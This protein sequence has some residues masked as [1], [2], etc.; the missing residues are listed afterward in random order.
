MLR[1]R[2]HLLVVGV[3]V[4]GVGGVGLGL[5]SPAAAAATGTVV[6]NEVQTS[7]DTPDYIELTNTGATAVDISGYQLLD[8]DD[9]D[10][11][12]VPADTTLAPGAFVAF[13][14][15]PPFGL[16]GG[17]DSARLFA[18]DG[19]TLLDSFT[20]TT[21]AA[22]SWGRCPDG[23]GEFAVT[24]S[25]TR[26]AAND[27]GP[28]PLPPVRSDAVAWPGP[29]TVAVADG[30]GTLG[31]DQ[32]G[33]FLEAGA[34]LADSVLWSVQNDPGV[35]WRLLWNGTT[36]TPDTANGWAHGK[37]LRYPD[38]T[39]EPDSE[40]VT[41]V[42]GDSSRG[43]F[44]S[45]ERD[46]ADDEVSK[47]AILRF[48]V[49]GSD[50][51]L[52]ATDQWDMTT[53]LPSVE[54]NSGFEAL[55][56]VPDAALVA[57]GLLTGT[58]PGAVHA[59]DPRSVG[60]H[61]G[62]LFLGGLEADGHVYAYAL[63]EAGTAFTRIASFSSGFPT[64]MELQ[65]DAERGQLRAVCDNTCEGQQ[66]LL[67]LQDG[68]FAA[69]VAYDRPTGLPDVNDEGFALAPDAF[70]VDGRKPAI[71][72]DDDTDGH[73]LRQGAVTCSVP[74][75]PTTPSAPISG[76]G[77][78]TDASTPP[79]AATGADTGLSLGVGSAAVTLGLALLVVGLHRRRGRHAA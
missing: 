48:D 8:D 63:D 79:L 71:W 67:T 13:D 37:Q 57:G 12:I 30:E 59:Y 27:C 72:A 74:A 10:R 49:A 1:E 54:P 56:Y 46:N 23:T 31:E 38:G 14:T 6:V 64:V 29:Q 69:R 22:T 15:D 17:S 7:G 60:P 53:D 77:G 4:A 73:A 62:G 21:E 3:L 51:E 18:A 58:P 42:G 61:F 5:A 40:G 25:A 50:T 44:V 36:W 20:W 55:T 68:T 9:H 24:A 33:L 39:G 76:S 52:V 11:V 32:S 66:T 26:G 75:P 47:P 41:L 43:V 70:C 2:S 16:G 45:T 19:T 65:W 78:P 28:A 34:S 35:L